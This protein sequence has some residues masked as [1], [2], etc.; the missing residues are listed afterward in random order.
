MNPQFEHAILS[1]DTDQWI[2]CCN[3]EL[4]INH[5][6]DAKMIGAS[7]LVFKLLARGRTD[8]QSRD[9]QSLSNPMVYQ[10]F[11]VIGLHPRIYGA[12]ELH[13]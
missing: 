5:N 6:K 3:T 13:Y 1:R 10:I 2:A 7:L 4:S 12:Q 11:S 9:D 8:G